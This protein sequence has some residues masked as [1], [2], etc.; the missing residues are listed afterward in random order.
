MLEEQRGRAKARAALV[1]PCSR[2]LVGDLG[3]ALAG[4]QTLPLL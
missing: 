3:D 4:R 2:E 1:L